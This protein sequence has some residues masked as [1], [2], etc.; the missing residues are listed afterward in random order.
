MRKYFSVAMSLALIGLFVTSPVFAQTKTA[1]ACRDEWKANKADNQAKGITE[2]AYITQCRAGTSAAPPTTPPAI[3]TTAP[4]GNKVTIKPATS[5]AIAAPAPKQQ[6]AAKPNPTST[7]APAGNTEFSTEDQARGHC[8]GDTI[9][10]ANLKSKIYHF[11][12]NKTYGTT[13]NGAYMCEKESMASGFRAAK[14][15]KHP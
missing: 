9:V 2:K 4:P 14:N 8:P 11:T 1:K 13:K 3:T 6:S 10:W 12:G 7:S 5:P 15:E